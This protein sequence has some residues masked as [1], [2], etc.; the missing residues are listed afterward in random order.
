MVYIEAFDTN[1]GSRKQKTINSRFCQ[2]STFYKHPFQIHFAYQVT[3]F[4]STSLSVLQISTIHSVYILYTFYILYILFNEKFIQTNI[5][6]IIKYIYFYQ[7]RF[8][9]RFLPILTSTNFPE[10]SLVRFLFA[11]SLFHT[12]LSTVNRTIEKNTT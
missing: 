11:I 4:V 1:K 10:K 2:A 7:I 3:H 8:S 5:Y 12:L 9:Y 6:Y